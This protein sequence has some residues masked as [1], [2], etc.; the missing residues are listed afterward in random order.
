M[1]STAQLHNY[2]KINT[3]NSHVNTQYTPLDLATI[4]NFPSGNGTGQTIGIIELGGGYQLSD[5]HTYLTNLGLNPN[6]NIT[7]VSVDGGHNAFT[8]LS[9]ANVE[10]ILDIEVIAAIAPSATLRVYFAPN[11]TSSFYNAVAAAIN[12]GCHIISISWGLYEAGWGSTNLTA[13]NNL[14]QTA[15]NQ[16][17][18]ILVAAGD[19]GSSDGASGQ[20]VDFPGSSI[21]AVSCGGSTLN[22]TNHVRTSEVVWNDNPTSSASGGGIS[23]FFS[24]PSY[25]NNVTFNLHG[26]RG[27]PDVSGN[28]DPNTGYT[29][30]YNGS[31]IIVGGTSAVAPLYAGLIA[32][33]NQNLNTHVG[34]IH[35]TLYN[36]PNDFY[37]ITSGNNGAYTASV[38]WD[39][40][41]GLG[42]CNGQ[43]LLSSFLPT[44]SFTYSPQSGNTPL[45]V[46]FTNTSVNATSYLWDFGDSTTSTLTNPTHTYNTVGTLTVTLTAT[47]VNGSNSV[48]HIVTTTAVSPTASFTYT[49]QSGNIPLLVTFTNTSVNATS[50]LWDFGDSTTS[51]LTNPTHTYDTVGTFTVTLTATN[52]NGSDSM[53]H[54]IITT[55]LPTSSF[56]YSPSSGDLPL[57]VTFTNTSTNAT[58]YNWNFGDHTSSTLTNPTHTYTSVGTFTVTLTATNANGSVSVSHTVIV[59]TVIAQPPGGTG[60]I[61]TTDFDYIILGHIVELMS[62]A[63]GM[64]HWQFGD[65]TSSYIQNPIHKYKRSGT[66]KVT[67]TVSHSTGVSAVTKTIKI[68]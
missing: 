2:L 14:F 31:Y 23:Q 5:L 37:D 43:L 29:I 45:L 17:I 36:N 20:N 60:T 67:L 56:T 12:D 55:D 65:G 24:K 48:T 15:A 33:I 35:P 16:N 39:A 13:M 28:A 57:L 26:F 9:D 27:V 21:Y 59:N 51:T 22:A 66:Y 68:K 3:L 54:T 30:Y 19:Q 61:G 63:A 32:R 7:D 6:V 52:N 47:N 40:C 42:V 25:Q 50:Y 1:Q 34:F 49:P 41:S 4:Y 11:T 64:V 10:V 38:A 53:T 58:S 44:A 46:A 18:T 8:P 62:L